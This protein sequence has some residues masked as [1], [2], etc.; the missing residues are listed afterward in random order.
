MN[1]VESFLLEGVPDVCTWKHSLSDT[2]STKDAYMW[3]LDPSLSQTQDTF[4]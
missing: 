1:V 4:W 2:Y 3:L